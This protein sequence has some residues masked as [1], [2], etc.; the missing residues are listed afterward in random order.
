MENE[1]LI[2]ALIKNDIKNKKLVDALITT[3]LNAE[4][5]YLNLSDLAFELIGFDD[6]EHCERIY[7][8]YLKFTDEGLAFKIEDDE[9]FE[10]LAKK[11]YEQLMLVIGLMPHEK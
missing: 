3:G 1:K 11:L 7:K 4:D 6:C 8:G 9:A 10:R 2:I 5:Y